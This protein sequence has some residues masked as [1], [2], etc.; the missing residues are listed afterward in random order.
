MRAIKIL[1]NDEI[2]WYYAIILSISIS[3]SIIFFSSPNTKALYDNLIL[4]SAAAL[5][6][7]SALIVLFRHH[8]QQ[9]QQK[10]Q[11]QLVSGGIDNSSTRRVLFMSL[12][13]GLI[14]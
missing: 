11:Q 1:N 6:A 2:K 13:A 7:S 14:L 9:R 10:L 5:A 12:A 4:D 3:N 8:R